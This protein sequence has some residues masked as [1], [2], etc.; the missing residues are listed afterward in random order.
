MIDSVWNICNEFIKDG[1]GR[2]V[3][4]LEDGMQKV[5][6]D[7]KVGLADVKDHFWGYPKCFNED[8]YDRD[9]KMMFYELVADSINYQYWYGKHNVRPNGACANEMY[10]I[11]NETFAFVENEYYKEYGWIV[12]REVSKIFI[13]SLSRARFPNIENRVRHINEVTGLIRDGGK[14]T[15]CYMK[16]RITKNDMPVDEFLDLIVSK[17]PGYAEDMFLKRAF[18]L[19]IMLY[20]RLGWF[21]EEAHLLPVPADYQVPKVEEGLGCMIYDY[22]LSEK[23]QNGDLIPAGSLEEC[24]IRA[25][26]MLVGKRL[27]ELS[28]HTMCDIDTYLWL[29]RNEIDK[30]FHL[31][32]T[33][34]Y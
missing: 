1:K 31:T 6:E 13:S 30:P 15:I 2:H 28:G 22:I 3:T 24:E 23:I 10:K 5:A 27:S 14:D 7:I 33:T 21:K 8:T 20:R 16:D 26:T 19:P 4:L 34:N 12:C 25:A 32:I 29:K 18:L 11:L 17:L 9:Y